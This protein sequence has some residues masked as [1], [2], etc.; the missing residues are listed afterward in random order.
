MPTFDFQCQK[1]G[2]V[3]E[4]TLP[5]GSKTLPPCVKCKS[6]R[7]EKL[8]SPPAIHFKGSGFYKTDANRSPTPKETTAP[9]A[10]AAEKSE[11][12]PAPEPSKK[13]TAK[14]A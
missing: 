10:P 7:V 1:C 14:P 13:D 9:A 8:M 12:K 11:S 4:E 3:F 5:F 6:K 2:T